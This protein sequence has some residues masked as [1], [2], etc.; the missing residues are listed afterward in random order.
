MAQATTG[1][2]LWTITRFQTATARLSPSPRKREV[3]PEPRVSRDGSRP[4]RSV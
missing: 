2:V 3:L 1:H 4:L